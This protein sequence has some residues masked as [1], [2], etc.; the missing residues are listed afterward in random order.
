MRRRFFWFV[1]GVLLG[2]AFSALTE[3][4]FR[5]A[6]GRLGISRLKNRIG[7]RPA[8]FTER[9]RQLYEEWSNVSGSNSE[10]FS[11]YDQPISS[12]SDHRNFGGFTHLKK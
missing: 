11:S 1:L 7:R 4:R 10:G 9:F 8:E 6:V 12:Y 2:V 3:R 5:R